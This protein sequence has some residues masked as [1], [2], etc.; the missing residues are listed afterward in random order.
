MYV[1]FIAGSAGM[2]RAPAA[3]MIATRPTMKPVAA[4]H[5][6]FLESIVGRL[7]ELVVYS[8]EGIRS[9]VSRSAFH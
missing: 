3:H 1:I 2:S 4:D 9:R 5:P 8:V 7:L 6:R